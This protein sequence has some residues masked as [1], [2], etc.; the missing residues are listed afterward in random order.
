M[1]EGFLVHVLILA[2][3]SI[4]MGVVIGLVGTFWKSGWAFAVSLAVSTIIGASIIV[5]YWHG[6]GD[7]A[8]AGVGVLMGESII[9][10]FACAL[11]LMVFNDLYY[12]DVLDY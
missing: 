6:H 3:S 9:Y 5:Q 4:T 8:E 7:M 10:S 2:V 11:G 12:K 1:P